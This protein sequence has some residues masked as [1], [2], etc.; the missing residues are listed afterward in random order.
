MPFRF[1]TYQESSLSTPFSTIKMPRF[2]WK[3][4][5]ETVQYQS[6]DKPVQFEDC[7]DSQE[8]LLGTQSQ[9]TQR[10]NVRSKQAWK[11]SFL[12]FINIAICL[13]TISVAGLGYTFKFSIKNN[14]KNSLLK[15]VDAYC[16][17]TS[18]FPRSSS[19]C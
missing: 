6:L 18:D 19:F 12:T 8:F 4:Q 10:L 15:M 3:K 16:E 7:D 5:G 11:L 14:T 2:A 9:C 13:V 17:L 1:S